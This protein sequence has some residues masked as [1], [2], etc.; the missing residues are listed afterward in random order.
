M[1]VLIL[2]FLVV[3][4]IAGYF[5]SAYFFAP[6]AVNTLRGNLKTF[7]L[8]GLEDI[9]FKPKSYYI[10]AFTGSLVVLIVTAGVASLIGSPF[11]R[12]FDS[13]N[14]SFYGQI[15]FISGIVGGVLAFIIR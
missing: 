3:Y 13:D 9:E 5:V 1:A 6:E 2:S 15:G 4:V 8:N 10:R 12:L 11:P 7:L 14:G